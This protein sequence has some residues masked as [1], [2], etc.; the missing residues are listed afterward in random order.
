MLD[1]ATG[2]LTKRRLEHQ[3]GQIPAEISPTGTVSAASAP[4]AAPNP[5]SLKAKKRR[6]NY[7][8]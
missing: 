7:C 3:N 5:P 8:A 2:E 6:R 4:T 1:P